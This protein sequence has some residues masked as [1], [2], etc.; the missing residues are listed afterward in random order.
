MDIT[1]TV[2]LNNREYFDTRTN[3]LISDLWGNGGNITL[4]LNTEGEYEYRCSLIWVKI[5]RKN[6][7]YS[8]MLAIINNM[9][10]VSHNYSTS[11]NEAF[12][13]LINKIEFHYGYHNRDLNNYIDDPVMN[14]PIYQALE[15]CSL[16]DEFPIKVVWKGF[17]T[18]VTK[19]EIIIYRKSEI[20]YQKSGAKWYS[21]I[22]G[23]LND[24][25]HGTALEILYS[26]LPIE[27]M[28]SAKK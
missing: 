26:G 10:D 7:L 9:A 12:N 18:E 1:I 2:T 28:K 13:G 24:M 11:Y 5:I 16:H 21:L 23:L 22:N 27:R 19:Y 4:R 8:M 15:C 20:L 3:I 6:K 14:Y 25:R 17:T